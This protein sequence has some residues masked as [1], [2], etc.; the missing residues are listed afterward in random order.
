MTFPKWASL[1]AKLEKDFNDRKLDILEDDDVISELKKVSISSKVIWLDNGDITIP[2]SLCG[3]WQKKKKAV[4][5]VALVKKG[6]TSDEFFYFKTRQS[7][8]TNNI[9]AS[10]IWIDMEGE[11]GESQGLK[12]DWKVR[13]KPEVTNSDSQVVRMSV[14]GK[15]HD[16]SKSTSDGLMKSGTSE[17]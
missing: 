1:K 16:C 5:E 6:N 4:F 13:L 10:L 8:E 15:R 7:D 2:V 14:I 17:S 11:W 9:R 3:I 12:P